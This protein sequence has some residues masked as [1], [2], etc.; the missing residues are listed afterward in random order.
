[1]R[2]KGVK[3]LVFSL[4]LVFCFVILWQVIK[5]GG[6]PEPEISYTKFI[7]DVENGGVAKVVISQNAVVGTYTDG[8]QFRV[9]APS[10]QAT[11]LQTLNDQRVEIWFRDVGSGGWVVWILNLLPVLLIALLL[12]TIIQQLKLA[13]ARK[14]QNDIPQP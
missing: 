10:N 8:A 3:R 11:M 5:A 12:W 7:S 4:V 6:K 9:T 2:S 1:M 13:N 14:D